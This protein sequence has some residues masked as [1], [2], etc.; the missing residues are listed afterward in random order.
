LRLAH[1]ERKNNGWVIRLVQEP[2]N[3]TRETV[4]SRVEFQRLSERCQVGKKNCL[5]YVHGYNKPF[6]ETLKQG[7]LLQERYGLEVVVF[8]WPSNTGS[9]QPI[10]Y[11]ESRRIAQASFGAIDSLLEK[12][13]TY[14]HE[15]QTPMNESALEKCGVT[16]NLM[17]HSLGNYLFEH[18]VLGS[19]YQA[20]TRVFTNVI[21]SQ[22]DVNS[23]DHAKWVGRIVAG[24]RIYVIINESDKI[25]GWSEKLNPPRL[26]KTLSSLAS[27]NASYF[28]FTRGK[29]VGNKHQLWGEVKNSVVKDFFEAVLN[30]KRGEDVA[31]F[32]FDSRLNAFRIS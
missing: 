9:L 7:W 5:F 14:L 24:Q 8:S 21:L 27:P 31:G 15:W 25:L 23:I 26:G 17:V 4:P 18:Y 19:A 20:E 16:V 32:D 3:M 10:E 6:L 11:R 13:S 2:E 12:Y 29:N 30:G 28:D 22:A 1:A